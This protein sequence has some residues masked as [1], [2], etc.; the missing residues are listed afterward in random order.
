[1]GKV[2]HMRVGKDDSDE[3]QARAVNIASNVL[4]K[5]KSFHT[6]PSCIERE[7]CDGR[8]GC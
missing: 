8:A 7:E 2:K 5:R 1:M 3:E 4:H 6:C